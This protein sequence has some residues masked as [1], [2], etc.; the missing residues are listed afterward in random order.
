VALTSQCVCN[1]VHCNYEYVHCRYKRCR[2]ENVILIS[3]R[4]IELGLTCVNVI[5]RR[6]NYSRIRR[7]VAHH[8]SH[9]RPWRRLCLYEDVFPGVWQLCVSAPARKRP[10]QGFHCVT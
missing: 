3:G 8:A 1:G 7:N 10:F 2:W 4:K 5:R 6:R 9:R